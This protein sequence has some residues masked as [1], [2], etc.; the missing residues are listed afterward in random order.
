MT[1]L[2]TGLALAATTLASFLLSAWLVRLCL[3]GVLWA[4]GFSRR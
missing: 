3:R 2:T 1:I 4:A